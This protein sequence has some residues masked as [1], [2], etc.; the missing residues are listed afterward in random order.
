MHPRRNQLP[1][2]FRKLPAILAALLIALTSAPVLARQGLEVSGSDQAYLVSGTLD[3]APLTPVLAALAERTG[4]SLHLSPRL[5]PQPVSLALKA[6][7]L[8]AALARLLARTEHVVEFDTAGGVNAVHLF[9]VGSEAVP[10]DPAQQSEAPARVAAP[11]ATVHKLPAGAAS[12][13][14]QAALAAS[15][16]PPSAAEVAALLEQ[17]E[18]ILAAFLERYG[19]SIPPHLIDEARRKAKGGTTQ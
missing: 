6:S 5:A 3:H 1:G 16:R 18:E 14:I 12:P 4:F 19:K 13:V 11:A 10:A 17:R 8:P 9:A 2:R 15:A 7:P